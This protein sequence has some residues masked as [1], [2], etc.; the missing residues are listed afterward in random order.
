V[1]GG[2]TLARLIPLDGGGCPHEGHGLGQHVGLK[3]PLTG[4]PITGED[5]VHLGP[6]V[7]RT[8]DHLG[9]GVLV[10]G[11]RHPYQTAHAGDAQVLLFPPLV[12]AKPGV[13]IGEG[14]GWLGHQSASPA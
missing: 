5:G 7:D 1:H 12:E 13:G 14:I 3:V 8:L 10:K 9:E 4:L 2:A 11:V 6:L